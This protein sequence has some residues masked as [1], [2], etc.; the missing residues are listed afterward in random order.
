MPVMVGPGGGKLSVVNGANQQ[1]MELKPAQGQ[2][3]ICHELRMSDSTSYEMYCVY[4]GE[5]GTHA[6]W[7]EMLRRGFVVSGVSGG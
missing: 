6:E 7:S 4:C 3:Q 5:L 1:Q 2:I